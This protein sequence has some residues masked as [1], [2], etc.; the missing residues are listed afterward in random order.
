VPVALGASYSRPASARASLCQ[1]PEPWHRKRGRITLL[2]TPAGR[3]GAARILAPRLCRLKSDP[4][5]WG[6]GASGR[7]LTSV[8]SSAGSKLDPFRAWTEAQLQSDPRVPLQRLRELGS[9][10]GL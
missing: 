9:R 6:L 8:R 3:V 1:R 4:P 5:R 2:M 10:A 7:V